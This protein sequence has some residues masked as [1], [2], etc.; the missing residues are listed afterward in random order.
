MGLKTDLEKIMLRYA[1]YDA[2][3][4]PSQ[5]P[6]ENIALQAEE[7]AGAFV[8]F[9]QKQEFRIVEMSSD[10]DV[11]EITTSGPLTG[12]VSMVT[13]GKIDSS[14]VSVPTAIPV[15]INPTTGTGATTAPVKLTVTDKMGVKIPTTP[16]VIETHALSLKKGGGQEKTGEL[17]VVGIA[18]VKDEKGE[19]QTD[20]YGI[21]KLTTIAKG[22]ND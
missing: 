2:N 12:D 18:T 15:Q 9:L 8:D 10:L 22:S 11:D 21:V 6:A 4:T 17:G 3:Y 1:G 14:V 5:D 16:N 13:G 19:N 20:N 7:M